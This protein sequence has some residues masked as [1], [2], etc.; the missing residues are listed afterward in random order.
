[1][2]ITYEEG[3][4]IQTDCGTRCTCRDGEFQC[5]SQLCLF[6]GNLCYA[7]GDPHYY[8]FDR[9]SYDFQGVCEYVLT[10]P[11]SS[12]EFSVIVTNTA[13]NQYVSCTSAVRVLVPHEN[14]DILLERGGTITINDRIQPNNDDSIILQSNDTMITRV[15]GHPHV[16]LTTSGIEVFFD[17]RYRVT[18]KASSAWNDLLCGLCGNY[19]GDPSDDFQTANGTL[20]TSADDFGSEWSI[21]TGREGCGN[22]NILPQCSSTIMAEAESRCTM[23]REG[24]FAACN[25]IVDP[26]S[27]INDCVYDY[28][29]CNEETQEECFCGSLSN[30]AGACASNGVVVP[31][32][33]STVCGMIQ[34]ILLYIKHKHV[35]IYELMYILCIHNDYACMLFY[36]RYDVHK[37][38]KL[39]PY[40]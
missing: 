15:G 11:C 4:Q 39:L 25:N 40:D 18:V 20:I 5:I 29:H 35:Y 19:N 14:L 9:R 33:R 24:E 34:Y 16:I 21:S 7:S 26:V 1:M 28:C 31:N 22:L 2:G 36:V 38:P 8:T 23:M 27:F 6:E 30:Y 10:Q 12:N 37:L 3:A 32:W 13:H 17:G